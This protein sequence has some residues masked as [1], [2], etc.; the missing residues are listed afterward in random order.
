MR[1]RWLRLALVLGIF[2]YRPAP[3]CLLDEV[4]APLDEANVGRF[5][6][7]VVQMSAQHAVHRYHAQQADDGDGPRSLRRDDGG[8]GCLEVSIGKVRVK[9]FLLLKQGLPAAFI[10]LSAAIFTWAP[11]LKP[12]SRTSVRSVRLLRRTNTTPVTNNAKYSYEFNQPKFYVK[13]SFLN[14]IETGHGTITFERM[15]EDVPVVES[16]ELSSTVL[17]RVTSLWTSLDFLNSQIELPDQART[18]RTLARC[19]LE[20][21]RENGNE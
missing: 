7:K 4:D 17:S 18:F 12:P 2:H 21:S 10:V 1:K 6:D 16:I 3:F 15:N 5:T 20:C 13:H 14:M 11:G 8:R 9:K 19:A